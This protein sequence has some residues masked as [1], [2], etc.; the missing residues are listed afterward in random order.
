MKQEDIYRSISDID[1]ALLDR[2]AKAAHRRR[3]KRCLTWGALAACLC[4]VVAASALLWHPWESR[5][6][7][8]DELPHVSLRAPQQT[9]TAEQSNQTAVPLESLPQLQFAQGVGEMA[10]DIAL[11]EGYFFRDLTPD[12]LA[13]IWGMD[14]ASFQWEGFSPENLTGKLIYDGEGRVWQAT[15]TGAGNAGSNFAICLSPEQLPA[16]CIAYAEGDQTCEVHGIPVNA[17]YYTN[18]LGSNCVITFLRGEGESAV[19]ARIEA[20]WTDD[21]TELME[22][23]TRLVSQSLRKDGIL[24]LTQLYTDEIPY[25]RSEQLTEAQARAED[26][27]GAY[28]PKVLPADF[29]FE[30]AG[31]QIGE[32]RDYLWAS[33]TT[34][35]YRS[36]SV[37]V[38]RLDDLRGL[39][40]AEETEKYDKHLYFNQSANPDAPEVPEEFWDSWSDPLFYAEE[41]TTEVMDARFEDFDSGECWARFGVLYAD[42][43]VVR[44]SANASREQLPELLSFLLPD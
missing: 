21:G 15:I 31:R 38:D 28:L 33:W 8:V 22:L 37:T 36:L 20:S 10:A 13:G 34:T 24:Q 29:C 40:H 16:S 30:N 27:L 25:W 23:L 4:M 19:G 18:N 32:D 35:D 14:A 42:G 3:R 44:V 17:V 41:L 26:A 12:Q 1:P 2:Y 6:V 5:T 43:T 11:P 7:P 9:D 39:V